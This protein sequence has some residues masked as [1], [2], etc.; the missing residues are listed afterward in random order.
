MSCCS[1]APFS[2]PDQGL[3]YLAPRAIKGMQ[4]SDNGKEHANYSDYRENI[5]FI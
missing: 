4:M 2:Q 5:G 1:E 3:W